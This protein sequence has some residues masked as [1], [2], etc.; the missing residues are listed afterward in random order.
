METISR[1]ISE[2]LKVSK[3]TYASSM[4]APKDNS[5]LFLAISDKINK[6]PGK[7]LDLTDID[8]SSV[9]SLKSLMFYESK[10]EEIDITGWDTSHT[11][12]MTLMF[13]DCKNLKRVIGIEDI[14]TSNVKSMKSM[15]KGCKNLDSFDMSHWDTS[16]LENASMMFDSC[17][18]IDHVDLSA[19]DLSSLKTIGEMF[20]K[21]ENLEQV[22]FG[23]KDFSSLQTMEYAFSSCKSLERIEIGECK[24]PSLATMEG[25]FFGCSSL[26]KIDLSG[27]NAPSLSNLMSTFSTCVK[28]EEADIS[29]LEKAKSFSINQNGR[30]SGVMS[31]MFE[32]CTRLKRVVGSSLVK[33]LG[34]SISTMRDYAF[35]NCPKNI[36]FE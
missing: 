7:F 19:N 27:I 34:S 4:I 20:T 23:D 2:K 14:D 9:S 33:K 10:I 11:E 28:L 16:S 30:V 26:K 29:F 1:Y 3:G 15:F 32:N 22:S 17:K 6:M 36:Q 25:A 31:S 8:V 18:S 5:E 12:D 24:M 21:C 13:F 35:N